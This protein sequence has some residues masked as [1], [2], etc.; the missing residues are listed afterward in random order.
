MEEPVADT[1]RGVLDGHVVLDREIAE[2]GRFPAV[3]LLRSV[4]RSLPRAASA[5]ENRLIASARRH[6]G[7]H[8]RAEL[9]L[10][11]GLYSAGSDPAIDEAI[12]VWPGLDAFLASDSS[13]AADAFMRLA[14]VLEPGAP[15]DQP[16]P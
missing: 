14:E 13:G 6:L 11:A 12:S 10:Q 16:P 8:D 4:S 2:R 1:L 7:V 3:D 9:M 5:E 15:T